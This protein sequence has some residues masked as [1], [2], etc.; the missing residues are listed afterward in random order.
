MGICGEQ[1]VKWLNTPELREAHKHMSFAEGIM[2]ACDFG[3]GDTERVHLIMGEWQ[4]I[5]DIAQSDLVLWFPHRLRCCRRQ[6]P[7]RRIRSQRNQYFP[8]LRARAPLQRPNPLPPRHHRPRHGR[9]NP[10]TKHT[11]SGLTRTSAPTP[12]K[13]AVKALVPARAYT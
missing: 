13:E 7:G 12:T 2:S 4:V 3:P 6:L 1:T 10:A 11:A 8:C 9:R 5:S